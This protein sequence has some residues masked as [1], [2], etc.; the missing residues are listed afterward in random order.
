MKTLGRDDSADE[1]KILMVLCIKKYE[2]QQ[3]DSIDH[4]ILNQNQKQTKNSWELLI[5]AV[6]SYSVLILYH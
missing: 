4:K 5:S 3:R 6:K 1:M 2:N